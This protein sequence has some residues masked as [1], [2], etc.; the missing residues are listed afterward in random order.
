MRKFKLRVWDH[1]YQTMSDVESI[2]YCDLLGITQITY[3][4][5]GVFVLVAIHS[6]QIEVMQYTGIK[7]KN[8]VEICESDIVRASNGEIATLHEVKNYTDESYPAFDLSP[9]F[10]LECNSFSSIANSSEFEIEVVGNI[11]KNFELFCELW[12]NNY[13]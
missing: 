3:R 5:D 2:S 9:A 7:D 1:R 13:E 12:R 10:D 6:R 4:A 11:H 8:G